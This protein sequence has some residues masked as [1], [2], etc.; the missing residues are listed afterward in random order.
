VLNEKEAEGSV[1]SMRQIRSSAHAEPFDDETPP[2]IL[3][4]LDDFDDDDDDDEIEGIGFRDPR[5][6]IDRSLTFDLSLEDSEH[7][8]PVQVG[9]F[10]VDTLG[11]I[12]QAT[13]VGY[14]ETSGSSSRQDA[15]GRNIPT[16]ESFDVGLKGDAAPALQLVRET[17]W[18]VGAPEETAF[19]EFS[20]ALGKEPGV[21]TA[22]FL[23][24][25][26]L[27]V[28]RWE[29]SGEPGYRLDRV[30]F[31]AA[32][33]EG[34]QSLLTANGA[35]DS[36]EGWRDIVTSDGGRMTICTRYFNDSADFDTLNL[37]VE[38]L[39]PEISALVYRL[40]CEGDFFLLPMAVAASE[41]TASTI[42]CDWPHVTVVESPPALHALLAR[43]PYR[44]W[45]DGGTGG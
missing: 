40:M 25:A 8:L 6:T 37:L 21:N 2:K 27:K 45:R 26:G 17:L 20:L 13:A 36:G 31:S 30:S 12:F 10:L 43:G 15:D 16:D 3:P 41:D 1:H 33:R 39:S 22:R 42:D 23:Q 7:P 19:G 44:W 32:Q 4:A 38:T 28:V 14:F 5:P 11:S 9:K 24:L 29:M 34:I 35:T 18:W